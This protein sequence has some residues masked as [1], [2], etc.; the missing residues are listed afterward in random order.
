MQEPQHEGE[1]GRA[2]GASIGVVMVGDETWGGLKEEDEEEDEAK[3]EDRGVEKAPRRVTVE[4]EGG[5]EEE[6]EADEV[7]EVIERANEGGQGVM[8]RLLPLTIGWGRGSWSERGGRRADK[9]CS[10]MYMNIRR[11]TQRKGGPKLK[12]TRRT[13]EVEMK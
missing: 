3:E 8:G 9:S 6:E 5:A 1:A 4:E 11:D 7:A 10:R 13:A 2:E 12:M